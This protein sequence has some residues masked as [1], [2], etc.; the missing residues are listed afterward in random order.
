[1]TTD[2]HQGELDLDVG[3]LAG[4]RQRHGLSPELWRILLSDVDTVRRYHAFIHCRPAPQCHYWCG[5]L[6]STG[7]GKMR[8]GHRENGTSRVVTAHTYGFQ[9]IHGPLDDLPGPRPIIRHTCDEAS[10][11]N[12]EHWQPGERIANVADYLARRHRSSGPLADV[13]GAQGRAEAIRKAIL[14]AKAE[15]GDVDQ[16]IEAA[17]A[18]GIAHLPGLF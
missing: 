3:P 11:Q 16:A 1:M 5:A 17:I 2:Y 18:Q 6:S 12:P 13:R 9:L 7:H 15:G 14:T 10:C 8:A 4:S